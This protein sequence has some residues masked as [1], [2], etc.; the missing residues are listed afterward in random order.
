MA[1]DYKR[2]RRSTRGGRP[3]W[4]IFLSGFGVGL[5]AAFGVYMAGGYR[6]GGGADCTPAATAHHETARG[7]T[8]RPQPAPESRFDFY[9]LLPNMEVEVPP[10]EPPAHA[11]HETPRESGRPAPR[12]A[13][14]S[15]TKR[16]SGRYLLQAGSFRRY[17]EA[18]AVKARLALMGL[19]ASIQ[20]VKVG[21]SVY[22]RVRVGPFSSFAQAERAQ[23]RLR[24]ASVDSL[25]MKLGD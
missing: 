7:Q 10:E 14:V 3:G 1:R 22:H 17:S 6:P 12:K 19:Q 16:A 5:I 2:G 13:E 11:P 23:R 4:V 25:L 20:K 24:Q 15:E 21:D 9:T 18:D 8:P